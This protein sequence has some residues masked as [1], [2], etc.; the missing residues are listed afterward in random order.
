[1]NKLLKLGGFALS[2][3][4]AVAIFTGYVFNSEVDKQQ[5]RFLQHISACAQKQGVTPDNEN[6]LALTKAIVE[7]NSNFK[8]HNFELGQKKES[9]EY[10]LFSGLFA[11]AVGV[12]FLF[13]GISGEIKDRKKN[14]VVF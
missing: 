11:L 13:V 1:M 7:N 6:Y 5:E 3:C 12:T 9:A 8:Q 4:A 14:D 10:I 2:L